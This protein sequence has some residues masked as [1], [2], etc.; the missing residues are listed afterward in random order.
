MRKRSTKNE[1]QRRR[2]DERQ[3]RV[4]F[5]FVQAG[6]KKYSCGAVYCITGFGLPKFRIVRSIGPSKKSSN[7][8]PKAKQ[9][10]IATRNAPTE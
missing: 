1:Q 4:L 10:T 5:V 2:N 9:N 8:L 3:K 6:R 7:A